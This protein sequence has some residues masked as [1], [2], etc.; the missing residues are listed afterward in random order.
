MKFLQ[1]QSVERTSVYLHSMQYA[2]LWPVLPVEYI[3]VDCLNS[4]TTKKPSIFIL[5][6]ILP[7]LQTFANTSQW[8]L[9]NFLDLKSQNVKVSLQM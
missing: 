4:G 8:T 6:V 9:R 2:F 1:V 5:F 3:T 7:G